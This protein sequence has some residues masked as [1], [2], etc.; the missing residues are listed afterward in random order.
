MSLPPSFFIG[1]MIKEDQAYNHQQ[2]PHLFLSQH[3][4]TVIPVDYNTAQGPP[5]RLTSRPATAAPVS[6]QSHLL[7]QFR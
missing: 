2:H 6:F 3:Q 1:A 5:H 7:P 4:H